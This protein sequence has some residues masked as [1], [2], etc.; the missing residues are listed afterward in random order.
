MRPCTF[1]LHFRCRSGAG[2]AEQPTYTTTCFTT[3]TTTTATTTTS[4]ARSHVSHLY[5]SVVAFVSSYVTEN[6]TSLTF[7]SLKLKRIDLSIC[8][9]LPHIFALLSRCAFC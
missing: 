7:P 4:V 3:T 1:T 5:H 2:E 9:A 8:E 6:L